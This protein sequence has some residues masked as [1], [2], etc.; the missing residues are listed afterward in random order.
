M[1]GRLC[2]TSIIRVVGL[3][4]SGSVMSACA[5][6]MPPALEAGSIP[7]NPAPAGG[8]Q[9]TAAPV[10]EPAS[11]AVPPMSAAPPPPGNPTVPPQPGAFVFEAQPLAQAVRQRMTGPVWRPGCPVSLEDLRTI[12]LTFWGFDGVER[13]GTLVVHAD[14]VPTL[15]GV[16]AELHAARWPI[17]QMRPIEDYG[18]DDNASMDADNTSAFNCRPSAGSTST[19]SQHAYGRAIDINPRENPYVSSK[20]VE[21]S[22]GEAF[23]DRTKARPGLITAGSIVDTSFDRRGW[24]WGGR[25]SGSKDY[26]H[27]S[28]T[29]R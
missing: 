17:R 11:T 15:R 26:Q 21:P 12:R 7:G 25:W 27:F 19:W 6:S 3:A 9:G 16:F 5:R 4:L 29:G 1:I 8:S 20:G 13:N 22:A 10:I 14:A 24:G 2:R 18:G 23:V 28:S